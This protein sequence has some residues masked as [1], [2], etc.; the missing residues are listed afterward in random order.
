MS[1]A[2]QIEANR[3]NALRSTG[4][5]TE[6]GK[7]RSRSNALKHGMTGNGVADSESEAF[8]ARRQS[9]AVE[10][11]PLG[12][13]ANWQMDRLVEASLQLDRCGTALNQTLAEH[14][15]RAFHSW[16]SDRRIEAAQIS[17]GL[18]RKPGWTTRKL[19]TSWHGAELLVEIWERLGQA[20]EAAGDWSESE[21]STALDLLGLPPLLRAGRTP[22]DAP[23]GT[24]ALAHL[25]ALVQGEIASLAE[26]MERHAV[27]DD[28]ERC[29]AEEGSTGLLS[30][31][32][33]LIL[34]YERDAWRHY[35]AAAHALGRP[36]QAES[37]ARPPAKAP[38]PPHTPRPSSPPRPVNSPSTPEQP[39][40]PVTNGSMLNV[41]IVPQSPQG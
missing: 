9:W 13:A 23:A 2:R 29:H 33:Q 5:K 1:T 28:M 27:L 4:P 36:T 31:P 25:R 3:E 30:K 41:S 40:P 26:S 21:R 8:R 16:D 15:G 32:A 24:D 20:L 14:R 10:Y 39:S 12:M 11:R 22:L 35:D 37:P 6:L 18:A 17:N 7:S 19:Q 38:T 34:R